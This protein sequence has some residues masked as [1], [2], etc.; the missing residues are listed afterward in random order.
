MSKV[1]PPYMRRWEE[2]EQV[3]LTKRR[4]VGG[5][6]AVTLRILAG[7]ALLAWF[8]MLGYCECPAS[9]LTDG[10]DRKEVV[11]RWSRG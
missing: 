2:G 8:M 4:S 1:Y 11:S 7:M 9:E 10:V 5:M 3:R 6:V